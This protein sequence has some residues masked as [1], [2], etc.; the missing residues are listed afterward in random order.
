MCGGTCRRPSRLAAP[1][2]HGDEGTH[3]ALVHD[4]VAQAVQWRGLSWLSKPGVHYGVVAGVT[5]EAL[6]SPG[7]SPSP[8]LDLALQCSWG[9]KAAAEGGGPG[10]EKAG[11]YLTLPPT[12]L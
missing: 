8:T 10:A 1:Y 3:I 2:H 6:A 9:A 12:V 7:Q 4:E 5:W 11:S